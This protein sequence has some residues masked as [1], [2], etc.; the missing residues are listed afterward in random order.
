MF[1]NGDIL[2][3]AARGR[4][5]PEASPPFDNAINPSFL[6][7]FK[8]PFVYCMHLLKVLY[9]FSMVYRSGMSISAAKELQTRNGITTRF[10][11]PNFVKLAVETC[12]VSVILDYY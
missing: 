8:T 4:M 6:F 3:S 11:D 5:T 10:L 7:V 2:S 12:R 9:I 1:N